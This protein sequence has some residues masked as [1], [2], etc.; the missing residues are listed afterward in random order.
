MAVKRVIQYNRPDHVVREGILGPPARHAAGLQGWNVHAEQKHEPT[1]RR[2]RHER[3]KHSLSMG[4]AMVSEMR[5]SNLVGSWSSS[6]DLSACRLVY[7]L[8]SIRPSHIGMHVRSAR[9]LDC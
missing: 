3:A 4:F 6:D 2:G 9:F 1:L 8:S 5:R 7:L